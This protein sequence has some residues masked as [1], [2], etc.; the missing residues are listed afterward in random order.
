MTQVQGRVGLVSSAPVSTKGTGFV[1]SGPG[2]A[3]VRQQ[4]HADQQPIKIASQTPDGRPIIAKG[5]PCAQCGEPI[6]GLVVNA[7]GKAYHPEHFVCHHCSQPFPNGEYVIKDDHAYCAKDFYDLFSPRC[8]ACNDIIIDK[9]INAGGQYFHPNHFCCYL[10]G[11]NL[12]GQKYK[13]DGD[14]KE[15]FCTACMGSRA[16]KIE[17]E[18]KIC[19]ICKRPIIGEFISLNG[20]PIHPEHYRC[21]E[22][23]C[24]F[25]GGNCHEYEGRFYCLEHYKQL[26]MKTCGR[27]HKP[28]LGRSVTALGR[29]WHPEHFT[30]EVCNEAFMGSQYFEKDGKAYCDL[31]YNQLFGYICDK[32]GEPIYKEGID[33]LEK[34]YHITC[35]IC[36]ICERKLTKSN[37]GEWET[38]PM[39]S[40]CYKFLP[41]EVRKR[42]DE[43]RKKE[44]EAM[45]KREKKRKE[46]T[47]RTREAKTTGG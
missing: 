43:R 15:I 24:E 39:C 3:W 27:C 41:T 46:G 22:C 18:A 10:C 37:L 11:K 23:G 14:T 25:V 44:I 16:R 28:V 45:K 31:H 4:Q 35:F 40:E 36:H 12:K 33:F 9:C 6:A 29:V 20:Q 13:I 17:P 47:K 38:K 7:L 42:M 32:C 1:S 2:A 19:S 5:P 34:H 21:E 8:K 30:C 26:I